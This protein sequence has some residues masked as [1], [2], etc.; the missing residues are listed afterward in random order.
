ML[1]W[2]KE[3]SKC[4]VFLNQ[5]VHVTNF[6]FFVTS[7]YIIINKQFLIYRHERVYKNHY[8]WMS[9]FNEWEK[10]VVHLP[11]SAEFGEDLF[12][13]L[14]SV[15]T[16]WFVKIKTTM[17]RIFSNSIRPL[18]FDTTSNGQP[19]KIHNRTIKRSSLLQMPSKYFL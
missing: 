16:P 15:F 10:N 2:I 3:K 17:I 8:H 18:I 9:H 4:N 14:F 7:L 12:S 19:V 11:D 5:L 13:C 6:Y 1:R